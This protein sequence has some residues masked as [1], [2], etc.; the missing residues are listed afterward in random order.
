MINYFLLLSK[1]DIPFEQAHLFIHQPTLKE[2]SLIGENVFFSTC[3]ILNFSKDKITKNED[4]SRLKDLTD[5]EILMTIINNKESD[6]AKQKKAQI[7]SLFMLLFPEFTIN[8]LPM[9]IMLSKG[10]DRHL[11]DRSNFDILR[12]IINQMFCLS[13][14]LNG[15]NSKYNPGGSQ[16]KALVQKFKQRERK[17][18]QIKKSTKKQEVEILSRYISILSV[19]ESKD[20]NTLLQYTVY[21][22]FDEFNRFKLREDF[23]MYIQCKLAGA[24]NL[25]EVKHWMSDLHL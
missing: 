14:F 3:D 12:K 16:A 6:T 21:Q 5:F 7:E 4:K 23:N 13:N 22:L 24:Q 2:I 19:G 11:I 25:Q 10:Q 9:S 15:V 17:L 1:N 8:F 20:M 18:S